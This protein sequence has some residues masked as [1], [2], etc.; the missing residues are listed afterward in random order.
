LVLREGAN[1]GF[2][3]AIGD[4]IALSVA[5]PQHLMKVGLLQ[6]YKDSLEDD[7]N[8][9]LQAALDR[10]AFLPFG[11]LIDKW[12]WN[13]FSGNVPENQWNAH[14]WDLR[15]KYQ[16]VSAPVSRNETD[17]DPGAKFHIPGSS[18][19]I[20]YFVAHLLEFQFYKALC[21][22]AGEYNPS[23]PNT[24]P[25]HK[26]DFYKSQAAGRKLAEGLKLGKSKHWSEALR[27]LTNQT[28]LSGS[29]LIEYFNPLL[30]FLKAKNEEFQSNAANRFNNIQVIVGVALASLLIITSTIY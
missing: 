14:W 5:T 23:N 11:L 13:V 1:P 24:K 10:V 16:K 28:E 8:A 27:V 30:K 20:G 19:Y 2:H 9:L 25:L 22:E 12:R 7:V 26:C 18:Q 3:E 21:M 29:A 17:F 6:D 4:T 15:E